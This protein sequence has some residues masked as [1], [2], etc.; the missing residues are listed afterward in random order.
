MI[1]RELDNTQQ[2]FRDQVDNV[3]TVMKYSEMP[4]ATVKNVLY[5]YKHMWESRRGLENL[6]VMKG[7]PQSLHRE[8][9]AYLHKDFV[10]RVPL[11]KG[12]D[13]LFLEDISCCLEY[14]A[15]L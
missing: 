10:S 15:V 5:F 7:L 4:D 14:A 11:F 9:L 12:C 3:V 6:N 8:L 1:L 2:A 13:Q